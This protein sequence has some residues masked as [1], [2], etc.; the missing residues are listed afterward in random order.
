MNEPNSN[1]TKNI[2]VYTRVSTQKQ[3]GDGH[4]SLDH[5][6]DKAKKYAEYHNCRIKRV[7]TDKGISGREMN[8]RKALLS[9][10]EYI[11]Y[12]D[13]F[14]IYSLSRL[15]RNIRQ[16]LKLIDQITAKGATIVSLTEELDTG[17][18]TGKLMINLM[19]SFA[20]WESDQTSK[21]VKDIMD[22]KRA[23]GECIGRIP[24]GYKLGPDGKLLVLNPRE[25]IIVKRII[26]MRNEQLMSFRKISTA[27]EESGIP[28]GRYSTKWRHGSVLIIYKRHTPE[29]KTLKNSGKAPYGYKYDKKTKTRVKHPQQ[30]RVIK[31]IIDMRGRTNMSWEQIAIQLNTDGVPPISSKAEQWYHTTIAN[32]YKK[33][34]NTS[35]IPIK[36]VAS[37]STSSSTNPSISTPLN[38]S[39]VTI[40]T[41]TIRIV[42]RKT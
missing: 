26:K 21:R 14:V 23:R 39:L 7:F 40:P 4:L 32:L 2:I 29:Y 25:Q 31:R 42:I 22:A 5:Q 12:G 20:Q 11:E 16:C 28:P 9:A 18:P 37:T 27:L 1:F 13:L 17:S 3:I 36:A 33:Y 38:K 24:Y 35:D 30:Q 10:L 6:V 8:N 15:S 19:A 34:S 41:P